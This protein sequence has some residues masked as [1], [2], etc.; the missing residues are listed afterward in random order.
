MKIIAP[1]GIL[2]PDGV[3][4]GVAVAFDETIRA[5]GETERLRQHYPDAKVLVPDYPSLLMPGLV[6]P[7]VHL[8]FSAN[9]TTLQYGDF[10]TWLYSVIEH[11]ETLIES[12]G[13]GCMRR[14]VDDMLENGITAFGAVSS[15]GKDLE[16]AAG[17]PQKVVFFNE[18]IGSQ[19]SMADALYADFL[20]RL[21]A[22]KAVVRKGFRPGVAIHS[23]YSVHPALIRRALKVAKDEGLVTT[24][25]Y[26]ESPAERR[27]LDSGE[28]D[29]KAFFNDLLKQGYAVNDARSFLAL[30]EGTPTLM[31]HVVH[32]SDEELEILSRAGHTVIHCPVSNRL[33]GNGAIDLDALKRHGLP[34][35]VGTDGLSSN[36]TLDLFEEMKIALFIHADAPLLPLAQRL[37]N[38]AT[39][40]AARALG[41]ECGEIK[42]EKAADMLLLELDHE[43]G[44]QTPL[45]LLL[46][47]YP[48]RRIYIDGVLQTPPKEQ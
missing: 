16:A 39:V 28:G 8:E 48:I 31:T 43:P 32:A 44:G 3:L 26:L 6:N 1:S 20:A 41:L 38:A 17:A 34:W 35:V 5:V 30:F 42:A 25:H 13:T 19:A 33:L 7:H 14:S 27:W 18:V 4:T 37:L 29:F 10:L 2:T 36:Y 12:C 23:P 21:D 47:R 24:A 40:D 9:R 45:H 15:H 11:R 22:S 46:H